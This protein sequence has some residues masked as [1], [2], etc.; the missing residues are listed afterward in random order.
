VTFFAVGR[1]PHDAELCAGLAG[2]T[3]GGQRHLAH[4]DQILSGQAVRVLHHLV[5]QSCGDDGRR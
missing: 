3:P 2:A 1:G 4:A 5:R